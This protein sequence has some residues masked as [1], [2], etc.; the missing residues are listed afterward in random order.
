MRKVIPAD[1]Q[2]SR[3]DPCELLELALLGQAQD[4]QSPRLSPLDRQIFP[5]APATRSQIHRDIQQGRRG[6]L[7]GEQNCESS[8]A[9]LFDKINA[10][11]HNLSPLQNFW[12]MSE[13]PAMHTL[14]NALAER[15]DVNKIF[16][17]PAEPLAVFSEKHQRHID[18][19][20]PH[21][22]VGT[23]PVS[24]RLL[25]ARRRVGMVSYNFGTRYHDALI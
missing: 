25:S 3:D 9:A 15:M 4:H 18:I 5:Q 14:P 23:K 1:H 20:L 8:A 2:L 11:F 12:F 24:C 19:P 13:S 6:L 10:E 17:I 22:H 16:K 21:S 7:Q